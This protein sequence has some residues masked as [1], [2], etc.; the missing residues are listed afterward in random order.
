MDDKKRDAILLRERQLKERAQDYLKAKKSIPTGMNNMK[1]ILK[2]KEKIKRIFNATEKQWNDWKWQLKH[3]I[4]DIDILSKIIHISEQEKEQIKE[5][6]SKYAWAISP[7]YATL[8]HETDPSCPIS[9]IC[10]PRIE[11]LNDNTGTLDPMKEEFTNPAGLITRR[12]PDRVIINV[13]SE[14]AAYCRF[15]QRRRNIGKSYGMAPR[16]KIIESIE[17]IKNNIEIRDVL[18]TGGD[19]LMLSINELEWILEKVRAIPHVEIIRIGTR[20]PVV[21]P[22]R[23]TKSLCAMLKKYHPLYINTHFNHP[24]EVNEF[25][26]A[27]IEKLVNSGILVGNQMVLLKGVNN[28]KHVVRCLN[29]EL[30]KIRVRPY[31]IFHPKSVKGTAHFKCSIDEGIEIMEHLRGYTSG[32]AI[33]YYIINAPGG[34]GKI[35]ILPK[36]LVSQEN[37]TYVFRTWE[38]ELISINDS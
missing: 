32:L 29:H 26:K 7:Y 13:T 11:E 3:T 38:G 28:D 22:M 10:I 12:Y 20:V 35:P 37:D 33:P 31:Y 25:S 34:L 19:A 24:M 15:C 5:V 36:Y 9:R 2:R 1:V 16:E 14:C 30:L 17:Y 27:A 8:M 4:K 6:G 18:I 21:L 23:I